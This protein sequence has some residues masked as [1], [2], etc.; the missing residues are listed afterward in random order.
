MDG[1]SKERKE[2]DTWMEQIDDEVWSIAGC[3]VHDLPDYAFRDAF[4]GGAS[5][6]E[7]AYDLLESEGFDFGLE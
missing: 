1:K 4:D 3:S 7:V 6:E 2:F 5:P